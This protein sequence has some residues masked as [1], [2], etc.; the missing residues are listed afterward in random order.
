MIAAVCCWEVLGV[1]ATPTTAQSL[2]DTHVHGSIS[3]PC[4]YSHRA[5]RRS[6]GKL[7]KLEDFLQHMQE[8][9]AVSFAIP[10]WAERM[11]KPTELQPNK[12]GFFNTA[13]S[14]KRM[15]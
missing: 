1:A 12:R 8:Q 7:A 13:K 9:T 4:S 15:N 5:A 6:K 3:S 11:N 10:T 2:D 14:V